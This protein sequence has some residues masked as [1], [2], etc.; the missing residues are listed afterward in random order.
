MLDIPLFL[1]QEEM[2]KP[3]AE[4]NPPVEW[5]ARPGGRHVSRRD[6]WCGFICLLQHF[7]C[8]LALS[9][10]L[11]KFRELSIGIAK[12]LAGSIGRLKQLNG[13]FEALAG[14]AGLFASFLN[15][16]HNEK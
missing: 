7:K 16:G 6:A 12:L 1:H 5:Q 10:S 13:L 8:S 15:F 9:M 4:I 2:K 3:P 11:E 14:F